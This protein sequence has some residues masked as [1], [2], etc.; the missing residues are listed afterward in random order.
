[1]RKALSIRTDT[2]QA[3]ST[4]VPKLVQACALVLSGLQWGWGLSGWPLVAT[5]AGA[6]VA[7]LGF[8]YGEER[9]FQRQ[10]ASDRAGAES[11]SDLG[12]R[13]SGRTPTLLGRT[14]MVVGIALLL[15]RA[16]IDPRIALPQLGLAIGIVG[17]QLGWI[18]RSRQQPDLWT[19]ASAV[20]FVLGWQLTFE[21]VPLQALGVSVL[22]AWIVGDRL[23]RLW[24]LP[25]V[26]LLF[27]LLLQGHGLVWLSLP[28][29]MQ[30]VLVAIGM[31]MFGSTNIPDALVGLGVFPAVGLAVCGADWLRRRE[32]SRL[33]HGLEGAAFALWLV[34]ATFAALNPG[35]RALYFAASTGM[36]AVL[37]GR[38]PTVSSLLVYLTHGVG[39]L[40]VAF[41]IDALFPQIGVRGWGTIAIGCALL[42]WGFVALSSRFE[43]WRRSGWYIGVGLSVIGYLTYLG[44]L[45]VELDGNRAGS[46]LWGLAWFAVPTAAAVVSQRASLSLRLSPI[47]VTIAGLI[48]G[49]LLTVE[50]LDTQ[51]AGWAI[52]AVVMAWLTYCR[53]S[54]LRASFSL[55]FALFGVAIAIARLS[56][57]LLEISGWMF[58]IAM[59]VLGLWLTRWLIQA[60]WLRLGQEPLQRVTCQALYGWGLGL[61]ALNLLFLFTYTIGIYLDGLPTSGWQVAAAWMLVAAIAICALQ[62]LGWLE[63]IGLAVAVELAMVSSLA[64]W[65][66]GPLPLATAN[67][68]LGLVLQVGGDLWRQRTGREYPKGAFILPT[69]YAGWGFVLSLEELRAYS[70]LYA[71]GLALVCIGLGR[72]PSSP[73]CSNASRSN[74]PWTITGLVALS[75]ALYQTV[76]FQLMQASGGDAGDGIAILGGL[77]IAIAALYQAL[78]RIVCRYLRIEPDTLA[79]LGIWHWCGGSLLLLLAWANPISTIGDWIWVGSAVG[80]AT[81]AVT[82]GRTESGAD[83]E[84]LAPSRMADEFWLDKWMYVGI[85]W[86]AIAIA[87]GLLRFAPDS[88]PVI[89]WG[90]AIAAAICSLGLLCPW[91]AWGW[92]ARPWHRAAMVLPGLVAGITL[93]ASG[94]QSFLLVGAYYAWL[95]LRLRRIRLSYLALM[96]TDVGLIQLLDST[97]WLSLSWLVLILAGSG[98]YVAQIDPAWG[99]TERR[100]AR[101]WLRVLFASL[102]CITTSL[103]LETITGWVLG[104]MMVGLGVAIAGLLLRVRAYLY[105]GTGTFAILLL[106]QTWLAI[107]TSS[108]A[109]W[110]I[111]IVLGLGLIW[112]AATFEARRDSTLRQLQA[113]STALREWE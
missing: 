62:R 6:I 104:G 11:S 99:T 86:G 89:Y 49:Q 53:P 70:G 85:A 42:E 7:S 51:L 108:I 41:A 31:R 112:I 48:A 67:L 97:G 8:W 39:V 13:T 20:L 75:V 88:S 55:G 79:G 60:R 77:A 36:L 23:R 83:T 5:Y 1:G 26:L 96:C 107:V 103:E 44:V 12:G 81:Y 21:A 4:S 91:Q 90:G 66:V 46:G 101:H 37:I 24:T 43:L 102:L 100:D 74:S 65:T 61:A 57:T 56:P 113:W 35:V 38:R 72:R 106:R 52:A 92:T 76:L 17:W 54:V 110:S 98:L 22:A 95:A 2:S 94:W 82:R 64:I 29:R 32:Q 27:G 58:V 15:A 63:T 30:Q 45:I 50:S 28:E 9:W 59:M 33:A 68:G 69:V 19:I 14:L 16:G 34:L 80:A 73:T 84:T 109:L 71:L 93:D 111:G 105:V 25:D 3:A 78:P 10:D 47:V 40:A 87:Y 18:A